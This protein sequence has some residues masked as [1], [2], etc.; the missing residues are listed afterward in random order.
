MG[1]QAPA[2]RLVATHPA[3]QR[4]DPDRAVAGH[5]QRTDGRLGPVAALGAAMALDAVVFGV[6]GHQAL[7]FRAYPHAAIGRRRHRP[8]PAQAAAG[9]RVAGQLNGPQP[10]AVVAR[11]ALG[12]GDPDEAGA[13]LGDGGHGVLRHGHAAELH[14]QRSHATR[15]AGRARPEQQQQ[16]QAQQA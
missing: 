2:R 16:Q 3:A 1:L 11:Q 12:G 6:V 8:H 13:V 9:R 15:G 4:A 10:V 14:L 7:E 5:R